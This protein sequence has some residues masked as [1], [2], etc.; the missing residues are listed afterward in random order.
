VDADPSENEAN[1]S[2]FGEILDWMLAPL[3]L[4]WPM[5]I[6]ITYLVA[7]SIANAPFDRALDDSASVLAQQIKVVD[8]KVTLSLPIP[9][10]D[11]LRADDT[12]SVY[13]QILGARGELLAG[14]ED[15]PLPAEDESPLPGLVQLRTDQMRGQEIRVA[16]TWVSLPPELSSG[17]SRQP[18]LVQVAETLDKRAQLA[19]EIVKGVILPQFVILPVAVILV[20]FGLTRGIRPLAELQRRIRLRRPD[21][22]SAIETHSAPEEIAPLLH[23][24]NELLQRLEQNVRAQ[25]RFIA[26]AAHQMKTPLAGLRMQAELAMRERDPQQIQRSLNL[27]AHSS[28][29]ATRLINQLLALAKA[30]S[31][32]DS[33]ARFHELDLND[34]VRDT[35]AD[36]LERAHLKSI[37]LGVELAPYPINIIGSDLLLHE[38]LSNLI[39]NA[40]RYSPAQS[41]V[42]VRVGVDAATHK[43]LLEVEDN[44]PGIPAHERPLVFERF[45]RVLNQTE[46]TVG[47]IEGSGLGLAIVREIA[48]QHDA[49]V[50]IRDPHPQVTATGSVVDGAAH[51]PQG[52]CF[53]IEF[54]YLSLTHPLPDMLNPEEGQS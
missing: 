28:E 46:S 10:R 14:E 11:I 5:S 7:K 32:V 25:K 44:G 4:L 20:W 18:A 39:D 52:T 41:V 26:D 2:L 51:T 47:N 12:D 13:F 33:T 15:I 50:S 21:D 54:P 23:S 53:L 24:F 3:L 27:L 48:F 16:Y 8:H 37:D 34:L 17:P 31:E 9:A 42:T 30:E 40:L 43:A 19:N 45:Y 1:R 49:T 36:W 22:L 6:A 29:R 35:V 38:L